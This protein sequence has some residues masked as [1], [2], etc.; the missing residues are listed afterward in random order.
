LELGSV[1]SVPAFS[2]VPAFSLRFYDFNLWTERKRIE[3]L[4]YMDRNPVKRGL[5]K[6]PE[7]WLWSSFRYCREIGLVRIND[8]GIM[9]MRV[10]ESAA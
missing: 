7:Q 6:A 9:R 8:C 5:V 4:R 2:P 1:P 3:K 10:I